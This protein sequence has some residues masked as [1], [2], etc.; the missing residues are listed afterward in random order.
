[1]SKEI[2]LTKGQSTVVDDEDYE[3]LS[4]NKW[5]F[6]IRGYAIRYERITPE[7]RVYL[8]M[9]R[10]ILERMIGR[11][12]VEGEVCDHINGDRLDNRRSNLRVATISQNTANC[13]NLSRNTTG[14]K[15]VQRSKTPGKWIA[16]IHSY[17]KM[18]HLGVFDNPIDAAIAYDEQ[19]RKLH[20]E[21]GRY[22]FPK[23]NERP[24]K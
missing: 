16:A 23:E 7:K 1:M 19:V 20:G 12:L 4:A 3:W 10:K 14:Y 22:N 13:K 2:T 9:H 15:G 18:K 11:S 5:Q 24:N 8:R 21:F 6:N 17:G